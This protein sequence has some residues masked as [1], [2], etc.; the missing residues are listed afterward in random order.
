MA[1]EFLRIQAANPGASRTELLR[2]TLL[3]HYQLAGSLC[4]EEA[5]G[6]LSDADGSLSK[7]T[8]LVCERELPCMA[9]TADDYKKA[10]KVIQQV[11]SKIAGIGE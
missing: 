4:P 10:V 9:G 3:S 1:N 11:T 8:V 2:A 5:D 6:M 7:L